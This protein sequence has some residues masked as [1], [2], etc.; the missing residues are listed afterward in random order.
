M[1]SHR[2]KT[3][4]KKYTTASGGGPLHGIPVGIKDMFDTAGVRTTAAF[5]HLKNRIP[6]KDAETVTKL[7]EAGAIIIGFFVTIMAYRP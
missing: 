4:R 7:K 2:R 3:W 1:P 5:E 6:K